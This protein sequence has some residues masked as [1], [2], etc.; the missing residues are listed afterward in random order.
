M[1]RGAAKLIGINSKDAGEEAPVH[2]GDVPITATIQ[3]TGEIILMQAKLLN[4][5]GIGIVEPVFKS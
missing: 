5:D 2:L 1:L 3:Q 4:I